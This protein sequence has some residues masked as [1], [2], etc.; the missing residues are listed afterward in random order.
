MHDEPEPRVREWLNSQSL[1]SLYL[2]TIFVAELRYG[3]RLLP[4]GSRRNRLNEVIEH[5][6]LPVFKNRILVFDLAA[7][8]EYADLM[9]NARAAGRSISVPDGCIAATAAANG[10]MVATRDTSPFKAAGLTTI[11]PWTT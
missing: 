6:V 10:M 9:A 11:N 5:K 3:V 7:S 1:E 2:S 4:L 8:D